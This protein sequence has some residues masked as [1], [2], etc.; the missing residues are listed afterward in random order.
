MFSSLGFNFYVH[1]KWNFIHEE[2]YSKRLELTKTEGHRSAHCF[3]CV[4]VIYR[5]PAVLRAVNEITEESNFE[6]AVDATGLKAQ[7]D[8]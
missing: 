4:H 8:L 5:L 6:T 2:M 7:F 3:F 1:K